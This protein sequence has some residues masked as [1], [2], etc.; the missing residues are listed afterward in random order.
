MA[1]CRCLHRCDD[2]SSFPWQLV[3]VYACTSWGT[4]G[5]SLSCISLWQQ[6]VRRREGDWWWTC[7]DWTMK[8]R[9]CKQTHFMCGKTR[10]ASNYTICDW[11][12]Q[13]IILWAQIYSLSSHLINSLWKYNIKPNKIFATTLFHS[14]LPHIFHFYKT[15]FANCITCHSIK[16]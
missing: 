6:A 14:F 5:T 9:C 8:T 7:D 12:L 10:P 1:M 2:I 4:L 16:L 15:W 3:S 11:A 13:T